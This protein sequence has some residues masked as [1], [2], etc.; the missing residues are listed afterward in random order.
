MRGNAII[1]I[2]SQGWDTAAFEAVARKLSSEVYA[3]KATIL[4]TTV[5]D[6]EGSYDVQFKTL[7]GTLFTWDSD[8]AKDLATVMTI[9]H[10]FSCDGP[11]LAF[12]AGGQQPWGSEGGMCDA[13]SDY[14]KSFW[15][16]VGRS[17]RADGKIILA[18]CSMGIG[19]YAATVATIA[20]K[21][22]YA[23]TGSFGAGD[24]ATALK[25]VKAI[26]NGKVLPPMQRY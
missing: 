8:A 25:H 12:G 14:A 4:K 20:G 9:S 2:P 24:E 17:L 6:S 3:G 7:A 18:G 16:S 15:E 5:A 1:I 22:V 13:L 23:A 11:N 19:F 10:G 26:E 21:P